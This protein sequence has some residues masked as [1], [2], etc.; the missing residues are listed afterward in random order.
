M[1]PA[2]RPPTSST[3]PPRSTGKRWPSNSTRRPAGLPHLQVHVPLAGQYVPLTAVGRHLH[4]K[5]GLSRFLARQKWDCPPCSCQQPRLP[6][7]HR[8]LLPP[9]PLG[10]A[11]GGHRPWP[12]HEDLYTLM[13][14]RAR[15]AEP[16]SEREKQNFAVDPDMCE[17]RILLRPRP[18]GSRPG[19]PLASENDGA[20]D[21]SNGDRLRGG[22]TF[23]LVALGV[24]CRGRSTSRR[25]CPAAHTEIVAAGAE[26]FRRFQPGRLRGR[27]QP[28]S[29]PVG[30]PVRGRVPPP[31]HPG[32]PAHPHRKPHVQ[33]GRIRRLGP[34]LASHRLR[35]KDASPSTR[36]LVEQLQEF[37]VADHDDGPD[38]LEMAIRLAE[39]LFRSRTFDDGLGN[40]LPVG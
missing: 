16:P 15:P 10:H 18:S 6:G 4:E 20:L 39:Q 35:F 11:L 25:T 33:T 1:T 8:G 27:G 22:A 36:L 30:R 19:R 7:R 12:E 23:A 38:A 31:G 29:G 5:W 13:R 40:R 14:L 34:Y 2:T 24:D 28:V 21:P 3:W 32:R 9:T 17:C 37:P 26:W